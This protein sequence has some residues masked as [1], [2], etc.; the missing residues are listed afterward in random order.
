MLSLLKVE[1]M[2]KFSV[3]GIWQRWRESY[4]KD[5]TTTND[6][7]TVFTGVSNTFDSKNIIA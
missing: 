2:P 3:S 7:I 1:F 6:A 4:P 5:G